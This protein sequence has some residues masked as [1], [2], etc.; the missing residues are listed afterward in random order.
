MHSSIIKKRNRLTSDRAG[1]I[2]YLAHNWK[3]IH[4]NENQV[5][6]NLISGDLEVIH[7]EDLVLSEDSLVIIDSENEMVDFN[8][9]QIY[10]P[11]EKLDD[12]ND[13]SE[14]KE[15][16]EDPIRRDLSYPD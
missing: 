6:D 13:D 2:C 3:L 8:S 4:E 11:E 7:E 1:K 5:K 16:E 14:G 15:V 12:S 9:K 10:D